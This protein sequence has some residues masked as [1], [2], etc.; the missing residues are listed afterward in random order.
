MR[1]ALAE[2]L[3]RLEPLLTRLRTFPPL[4][5]KSRGVFYLKGRAFLHFHADPAGLFADVRATD[6]DFERL[7]VDDAAG[8]KALLERVESSIRPSP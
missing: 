6:G 1:H 4:S 7:K 8:A 2:D 3:D 5:E